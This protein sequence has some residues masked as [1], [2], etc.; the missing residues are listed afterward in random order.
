MSWK[1]LV[2]IITPDNSERTVLRAQLLGADYN[3][4]A[5]HSSDEALKH[6]ADGMPHIIIIDAAHTQDDSGSFS[7][8]MQNLEEASPMLLLSLGLALRTA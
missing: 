2:Y 3:V 7:D 5:F 8:L 4:A 1:P 6:L